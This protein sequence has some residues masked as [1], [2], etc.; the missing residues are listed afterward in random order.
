LISQKADSQKVKPTLTKKENRNSLT[1]K[2]SACQLHHLYEWY[3]I[4]HA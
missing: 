4:F 2:E 3:F 1:V